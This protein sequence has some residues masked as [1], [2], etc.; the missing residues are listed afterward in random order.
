MTAWSLLSR[1]AP[2]SWCWILVSHFVLTIFAWECNPRVDRNIIP[3]KT[4]EVVLR[5]PD[6]QF[7]TRTI[8]QTSKTYQGGYHANE[9]ERTVKRLRETWSNDNDIATEW[10]LF[11]ILLCEKTRLNSCF[12]TA[13]SPNLFDEIKKQV[14][15]AFCISLTMNILS[16]VIIF[17]KMGIILQVYSCQRQN[18]KYEL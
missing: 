10:E 14:L 12:L 6:K 2:F 18:N 3:L 16:S 1:R 13:K 15:P 5:N 7:T 17:S 8:H 4:G 11:L 9:G